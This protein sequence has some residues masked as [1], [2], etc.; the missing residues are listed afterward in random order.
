M[1][2]SR[3]HRRCV[4][5]TSLFSSVGDRVTSFLEWCCLSRLFGFGAWPWLGRSGRRPWTMQGRPLNDLSFGTSRRFKLES[6]NSGFQS[7]FQS[8]AEYWPYCIWKTPIQQLYRSFLNPLGSKLLVRE[9]EETSS[10]VPNEQVCAGFQLQR[11]QE[12]RHVPPEH[13]IFP[14][15]TWL[16]FGIKMCFL[17]LISA[18]C[19]QGLG[20]WKDF[21][22]QRSLP[23]SNMFK[24]SKPFDFARWGL[25]WRIDQFPQ[26]QRR[27]D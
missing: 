25:G 20:R 19:L 10:H 13:F 24:C 7:C 27:H 12:Q 3:W 23:S 18:C 2:P 14:C 15:C 4:G 21:V 11:R 1:H 8:G 22:Q 26:L 16:S 6:G 17:K 5:E 9:G